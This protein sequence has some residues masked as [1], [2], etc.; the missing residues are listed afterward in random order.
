MLFIVDFTKSIFSP[1]VG[2]RVTKY[3]FFISMG[4]FTHISLYLKLRSEFGQDGKNNLLLRFQRVLDLVYCRE[5][6]KQDQ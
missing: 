6:L 5:K 2:R 3:F 4:S 1:V